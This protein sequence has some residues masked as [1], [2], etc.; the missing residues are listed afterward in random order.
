MG[1]KVTLRAGIDTGEVTSGLVGRAGLVYDL[2]GGAV[3][4]ASK[5]RR[6]IAEPGIYVSQAVYEATRDAMNYTPAGTVAVGD[7]EEQAWRL[8]EDRS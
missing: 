7:G 5:M 1:S 8:S 4:L 3:H 2:W 6:G